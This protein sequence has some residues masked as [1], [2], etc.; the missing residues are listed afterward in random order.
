MAE[1][2]PAV[3]LPLEISRSKNITIAN[4]HGYRVVS[5]FQPFPY[6]IRVS[7]SDAIRFRNVHVDSDSKA[8]FDNSVFNQTDRTEVRAREFSGLNVPGTATS[9]P[10]AGPSHVL[11][12]GAR[13]E[14]LASGFFN[15]SG[16][17]I[18]AS[19]QLYFVDAHWQ[20][21]YKWLPEAREAAI[22]RDNPLD[23]VNLFFDKAGDLIVVSYGGN[24]TVYSFRPDSPEYEMTLLRPEATAD[25]S[26]MSPFL[27]ANVWGTGNFTGTISSERPFQYLSPDHT[28]FLPAGDDFVQGRLYYG[29]KMADILRAFG[30]VRAIPGR[31]FYVSDEAEEKT[32]RAEVTSNGT[33]S[34]PQLF[35]EQGGESVAQDKEGN[36]Y[37]SAGQIYVYNSKGVRIETITVPERP[38]D[39][40]FDGKDNRT[41]FILAHSS[42]YALRTRYGGL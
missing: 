14:R 27:A 18:D 12:P 33:L 39:L 25:H 19:G 20:R 17:A 4:Y 26:A 37:L 42:L 38:I 36:V 15:I 10:A 29:T 22:V 3:T 28:V 35:A 5:S 1:S 21:I 24:G 13:V 40:L 34:D 6:A 11:E 31:P 9:A 8:S 2:L 7:D 32:Y 16:A 23:P 30:L 41:L